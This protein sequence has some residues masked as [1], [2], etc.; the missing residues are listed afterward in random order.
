MG[1]MCVCVSKGC[2]RMRAD[3]TLCHTHIHTQTVLYFSY[4]SRYDTHTRTSVGEG[5]S[6][7]PLAQP[8]TA[9][10]THNPRHIYTNQ[11]YAPRAAWA[12]APG[13]RALPW[14]RPGRRCPGRS[15]FVCC[16]CVGVRVYERG[17]VCCVCECV[18]VF[19]DDPC[20]CPRLYES[21]DAYVCLMA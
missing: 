4:V 2:V 9:V 19:M 10:K 18:C 3:G 21:M 13:T 14:L 20:V 5:S 15:C 17:M 16:R 11:S 6:P 7:W 12:A 8:H 1:G